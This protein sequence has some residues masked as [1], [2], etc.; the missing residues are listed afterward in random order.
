MNKSSSQVKNSE[1]KIVPRS[2]LR[3]G[4]IRVVRSVKDVKDVKEYKRLA[5]W[6]VRTLL[7]CGKLE[8]LK[9]EMDKMKIDILGISEMR[10]P[11]S[12]DFWSGDHR[13]IDK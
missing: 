1:G 13:I 12:G 11:K 5:T 2:D 6:N 4:T 10:W 7:Q 9:I 8:N 3:V